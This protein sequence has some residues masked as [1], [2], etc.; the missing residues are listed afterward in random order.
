MKDDLFV[1]ETLSLPGALLSWRAV[2]ASGPG[3][4][5]VNKVASKVKLRFSF[6]LCEEIPAYA[7]LRLRTAGPL[8][9]DGNL[10]IVSQ[11]TRD[12]RKNLGDAQDK[13][14]ALVRTSLIQLKKRKATKPSRGMQEHRIKEKKLRGETK[15]TRTRIRIDC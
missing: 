8:D 10:L 3:G 12:Q 2:R 4:Q 6:E 1:S 11:K 13:L 9:T 7:K 14:V 15:K 5:N